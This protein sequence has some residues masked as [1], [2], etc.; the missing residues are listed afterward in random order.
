MSLC[1]SEVCT[2]ICIYF[3]ATVDLD[4]PLEVSC[5]DDTIPYT[6]PPHLNERVWKSIRSSVTL[7]LTLRKDLEHPVA[8]NCM[9]MD[10]EKNPHRHIYAAY[11]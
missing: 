7:K 8:L 5:K 10:L 6:I 11:T 3:T 1:L 9:S 4:V 2:T